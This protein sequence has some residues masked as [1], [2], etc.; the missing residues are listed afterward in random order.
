MKVCLGYNSGPHTGKGFFREMLEE[1]LVKQN[2]EITSPKDKSDIDLQFGKLA[3]KPNAKKR[4]LRL[5]PAHINSAQDI[6]KLNAPK[7]KAAKSSHGIIY[8]SEFSKKVCHKF[9]GRPKGLETV[10]L[11][12]ANKTRRALDGGTNILAST[13]KWI[14]QKRLKYIIQAF[15]KLLEMGTEA[16]L[17]ILGDIQNNEK[18]KHN[19]I[20]YSGLK[21]HE[22][23]NEIYFVSDM[24]VHIVYLDACPNSVAEALMSGIPVV[25]TDQ[26]G[27]KE[28]VRDRGI[29]IPDEPY[30]FKVTNLEKPPKVDTD[31]LALAM[32]ECLKIKR[33][34]APDLDINVVAKQYIDFFEKV[35]CQK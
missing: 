20:F 15:E 4:I 27:T 22:S 26:G 10:I 29:I 30:D 2:I 17:F 9:I 13:R 28:L 33:V 32:N 11:N 14:P 31:K 3:Y 1:A 12:G 34:S 8:Q 16:N 35:L 24:M 6:K 25:C 21:D 23:L 18:V 5:G 7:W 19:R